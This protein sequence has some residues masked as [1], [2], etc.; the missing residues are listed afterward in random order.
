[1]KTSK[2]RINQLKT[3]SLVNL[4]QYEEK[5]RLKA[6]KKQ[7]KK[8]I[9]NEITGPQYSFDKIRWTGNV[10][11]LV[12]VFYE[13]KEN[14][15]IDTSWENIKRVLLEVFLDAKNKEFKES[16]IQTYL[17]PNKRFQTYPRKK[18]K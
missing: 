6:H 4:I 12:N 10:N 15:S 13:L 1:M 8:R 16:T 14:G 5:A 3:N 2:E 9:E 17:K 18:L 11:E 7:I